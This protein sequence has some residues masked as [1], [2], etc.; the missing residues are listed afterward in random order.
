MFVTLL[1]NQCPRVKTW[2]TCVQNLWRNDIFCCMVSMLHLRS[3]VSD[4]LLWK[5]KDKSGTTV[6][7]THCSSFVKRRK[8]HHIIQIKIFTERYRVEGTSITENWLDMIGEVSHVPGRIWKCLNSPLKP[9]DMLPLLW[10][11][12]F[13][14]SSDQ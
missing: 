11:Y 8:Q 13:D 7:H 10:Y 6:A 9:L 4:C 1:L 12:R 14:T 3:R 2:Y 5:E